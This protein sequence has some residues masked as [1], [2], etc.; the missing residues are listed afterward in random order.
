VS[1][2]HS[3]RFCPGCGEPVQPW[4]A[5]AT[6]RYCGACGASLDLVPDPDRL[7][8]PCATPQPTGEERRT[9]P[10]APL[11]PRVAAILIDAIIAV[12][13]VLPGFLLLVFGLVENRRESA[14]LYTNIGG[15]LFVIGGL[16]F[17]WYG[18]AKDGFRVGQSIGK[19]SAG[20]IVVHLATGQPCTRT[21]SL[22]RNLVHGLLFMVGGLPLL[23]EPLAVLLDPN[24]RR[25]GDHVAHTQVVTTADYELVER[26]RNAGQLESTDAP[27]A[28]ESSVAIVTE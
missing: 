20:L 17:F 4:N 12:S 28:E 19:R 3:I 10:R 8:V 7:R 13:I 15:A 27:S 21:Q 5:L 24:G 11:G 2:N 14:G 9:Y 6:A 25:I 22:I 26:A 1:A 18:F 16:W 23:L